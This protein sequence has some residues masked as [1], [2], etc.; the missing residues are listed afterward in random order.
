MTQDI[1]TVY[2]GYDERQSEAFKA[3]KQ[4][5][6]EFASKPVI[7]TPLA[8][9][10]LRDRGLFSRPWKIPENGEFTDLTDGRPFSTQFSHSRFLVP[11]LARH[12]KIKTKYA[13]F[14]DSDFVFLTDIYKIL[15]SVKNKTYP[16][17]CVKHN[18]QSDSDVKMDGRNQFNYNK[19]LWTSLM[20]FDVDN[21]QLDNLDPYVVNTM[22]GRDMHQF[23]WLGA[24]PE[25]EIGTI[26]ELWNFIPGH[27][28]K[29][30]GGDEGI[31][32]IHFTSGTPHME[33]YENCD[34]SDFYWGAYA[35]A[36]AAEGQEIA[37]S[38][39]K[40][41]NVNNG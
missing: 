28:E 36:L 11:Y 4:S 17:F 10:P 13:L 32:A 31:N 16:V 33:G 20:L 1:L 14:V 39:F 15:N 30:V 38:R 24:F 26:P 2:I 8:H 29:N 7:I 19:K 41:L 35:R 40:R 18:Y 34:Y 37:D 22:S 27:S 25:N 6:V 5:I 12:Q 3:C 9:Q 23:K 21:H